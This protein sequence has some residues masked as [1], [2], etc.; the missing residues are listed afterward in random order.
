MG[1]ALG[2]G[3]GQQIEASVCGEEVGRG[4]QKEQA[5]GRERQRAL[6]APRPQSWTE[7]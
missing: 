2:A 7:P 5:P 6:T 1:A 4:A 3:L